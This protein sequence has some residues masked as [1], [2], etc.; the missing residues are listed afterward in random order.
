MLFF[1]TNPSPLQLSTTGDLVIQDLVVIEEAVLAL[2]QPGASFVK[3]DTAIGS[4]GI[5]HFMF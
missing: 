1:K 2:S 4:N 5:D 3:A